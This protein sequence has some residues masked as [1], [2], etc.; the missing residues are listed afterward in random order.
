MKCFCYCV[1]KTKFNYMYIQATYGTYGI[2]WCQ[3]EPYC[4]ITPTSIC[5]KLAKIMHLQL[6]S[7]KY[8]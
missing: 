5:Y 1:E 8:R 4:K 7:F 3:K 2:W 6:L